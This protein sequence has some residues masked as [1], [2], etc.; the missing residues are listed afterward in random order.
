MNPMAICDMYPGAC[1][2]L[3]Y[4]EGHVKI[5]AFAKNV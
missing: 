2:T 4:S 5:A 1:R 3:Q